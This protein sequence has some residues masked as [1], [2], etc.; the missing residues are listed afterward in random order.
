MG[1]RQSI[2]NMLGRRRN[3]RGMIWASLIGLGVS[4]AAYGLSRTQNR[5]MPNPVQ[6]LMNNFRFNNAVKMPNM[7]NL[8]EFSKEL[9]P[10]KNSYTNK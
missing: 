10:D 6:N 9:V 7:A 2:L 5:N 8:T 3:N 4:A 1:G